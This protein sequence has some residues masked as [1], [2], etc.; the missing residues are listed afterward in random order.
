MEQKRYRNGTETEGASEMDH[1]WNKHET[2]MEQ[3]RNRQPHN[4]GV[5]QGAAT[6]INFVDSGHLGVIWVAFH[7]IK[8]IGF[9]HSAGNRGLEHMAVFLYMFSESYMCFQITEL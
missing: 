4:S 1:R 6:K 9:C 3:K 2:E 8:C 7:L 5:T